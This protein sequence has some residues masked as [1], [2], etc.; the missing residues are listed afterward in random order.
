MFDEYVTKTGRLSCKQPQEVKNQWYILKF[1]EI[2][3]DTYDYSQVVYSDTETKVVIICRKHGRFSQY[4]RGH[5]QGRGCPEC[6]KTKTKKLKQHC[7][8]IADF[9]KVH[10]NRYNYSRVSY[11]G[12]RQKITILCDKHGQFS[13]YPNDHLKGQGC[14][15]CQHQ[16]QNILY[17]LK[18]LDTE[19]IKIGITNSLGKRISSIGGNLKT[20]GYVVLENPRQVEKALHKK[21][22]K[23]QRFN[24]YVRNGGTEFFQLSEA[25]VI[26]LIQNISSSKDSILL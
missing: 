6:A 2:H 7:D 12:V 22:E 20:L 3:G 18:C 24:T 15:K 19:L 14:P 16:N 26:E 25:Q 21:Y 13:Q 9:I 11:T 1:Q 23:Y 4:I 8:L 17:V 5:R 10:G